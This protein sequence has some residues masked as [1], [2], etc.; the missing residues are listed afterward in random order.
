MRRI[1]VLIV[2]LLTALLVGC[3]DIFYDFFH[4]TETEY[5][6]YLSLI[7]CDGTDKVQ[8]MDTESSSVISFY[9]EQNIFIYGSRKL[10][11][12][13]LN[14][15]ESEVLFPP[16][17]LEW[18]VSGFELYDNNQ[19]ILYWY[20]RADR[21]IWNA[22]IATGEIVNLTNTPDI[23]EDN[24]KLSPSEELFVYTAINYTVSD[25]VIWSL[26]YRDFTNN[27]A[28]TVISRS[29]GVYGGF[30]YVDW[31]SEDKLLYTDNN[32]G[33]N[34]GIYIINLDGTDKQCLFEG[35]YIN[36]FSLNA[37]RTKAVFCSDNEIFLIDTTTFEITDLFPGS[38]PKLSPDGK[39]IAYIDSENSISIFDLDENSS[40]SINHYSELNL[41]FSP[42]SEKLV[43]KE[44]V[45]VVISN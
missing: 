34:P 27:I 22:S 15:L 1:I 43:F 6:Y 44:L 45:K 2:V 33:I 36:E 18:L 28:H 5:H 41:E 30:L 19:Q 38:K 13:N 7:N 23:K 9:D 12:Y 16:E 3:S 24:M 11:L 42:D 26:E 8:L 20:T 29:T 39:K 10:L 40:I 17:N 32:A 31:I 35:F 21:D 37:D 4:E 14:S 25:S